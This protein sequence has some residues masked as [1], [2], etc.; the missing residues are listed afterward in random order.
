MSGSSYNIRNYQPADF[1][2]YVRFNVEAD[3]S[4]FGER[5]ISPRALADNLGRPGYSPELDLFIAEA[6]GNIVGYMDVAPE[7]GIGRVILNCFIHPDY[8]RQGLAS[9]L[10]D[11]AAQRARELGAR[12][13]HVNVEEGNTVASSVLPRLDFRFI[14]R[15]LELSMDISRVQWQGVDQAVFSCR[16]LHRGEEEKLTRI[17][18]RSFAD[19]WGYNPNTEGE[20]SYWT[21]LSSCSPEDVVLVC[22]GDKP[23]GY[24]WTRLGCEAEASPLERKGQ[25][26]MLGVEPDY[27]GSGIG[28]IVLMAGLSYLKEKGLQVVDLTVD[29]E[30]TAACALYRSAGFEVRT[31]SLW[32]EKA[33][34]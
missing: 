29:S 14:R 11:C 26:F 32:Y 23:A 17:Q 3:K 6:A 15:F 33:V 22:D 34:D 27:R 24:C 25:I 21:G 20:V 30:N 28:R 5:Y 4:E 9:R 19:T 13:A 8:R 18:N 31:S 16:H 1:D 10:L 2:K 7:V 12:V